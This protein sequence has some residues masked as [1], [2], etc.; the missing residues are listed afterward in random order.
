M[1]EYATR[2]QG[3][4]A[5]LRYASIPHI[6]TEKEHGER[7]FRAVFVFD[8]SDRQCEGLKLEFF[9]PEGIAVSDARVLLLSEFEIRKTIANAFADGVWKNEN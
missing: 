8:D 2:H 1:V 5:L 6:R 4:A 3:L 7:G 9:S